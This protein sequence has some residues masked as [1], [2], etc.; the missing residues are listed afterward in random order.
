MV[1][2][3]GPWCKPILNPQKSLRTRGGVIHSLNAIVEQIQGFL[4]EA[5]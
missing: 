3:H 4:L 1:L 2:P 5:E